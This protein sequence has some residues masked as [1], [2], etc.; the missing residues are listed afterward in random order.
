[1]ST[2]RTIWPEVAMRLVERQRAYRRWVLE[3]RSTFD[4]IGL[5][6]AVQELECW[7]YFLDH[8][9]LSP[10]TQVPRFVIDDL[11]R[12]G[13]AELLALLETVVPDSVIARILR[14]QLG[15]TTEMHPE[16]RAEVVD[17]EP[18]IRRGRKRR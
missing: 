11:T 5:P 15:I 18:D 10:F 7:D 13:K 3:H 4:R 16:L 6:L 17:E 8:G 14:V 1:M 9:E 2:S 12:E